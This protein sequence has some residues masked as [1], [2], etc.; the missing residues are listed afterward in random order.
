MGQHECDSQKRASR[1][2]LPEQECQEKTA[3]TGQSETQDSR[4]SIAGTGHRGTEQPREDSQDRTAWKGKPGLPGQGSNTGLPGQERRFR[5]LEPGFQCYVAK[6]K[7]GEV[8][9]FS[10]TL[11]SF[12]F[13]RARVF[14]WSPSLFWLLGV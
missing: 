6:G 9:L 12:A 10:F 7:K 2:G 1:T 4:D 8:A 13:F 5:A 11:G 3:K 14:L